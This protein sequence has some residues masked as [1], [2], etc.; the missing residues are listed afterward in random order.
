MI[1]AY[2]TEK[3]VSKDGTIQLGSLPFPAGETV[4]VIVLQRKVTTDRLAERPLKGSVLSYEDP[5]HQTCNSK[6]E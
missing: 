6:C 2:S 4:Q 5:L 3:M 1:A